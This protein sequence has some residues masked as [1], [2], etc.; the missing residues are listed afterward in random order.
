LL[1]HLGKL[2]PARGIHLP[3]GTHGQALDLK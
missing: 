2:Q 3:G 1:F